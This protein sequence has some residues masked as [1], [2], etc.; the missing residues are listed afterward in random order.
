MSRGERVRRFFGLPAR[1]TA[2]GVASVPGNGDCFYHAVVTALR[3]T[4]DERYRELSVST[5]REL[6]A[7]RLTYD[8]VEV[9]SA[10]ALARVR[11]YDF[12]RHIEAALAAE[13]P[14]AAELAVPLEQRRLA[15]LRS[16]IRQCGT[17]V[18]TGRCIWADE[19][20]IQAVAEHYR[21]T[22][23]ILNEERSITLSVVAP[24]D[25]D[26][27]ANADAA[28]GASPS[29]S[30]MMYV[31]LHLTRR[32]HYDALWF[33]D[34]AGERHFVARSANDLP[35]AIAARFGIAQEAALVTA[36]HAPLAR[37]PTR[38]KRAASSSSSSSSS[39]SLQPL[40]KRQ[41]QESAA[42]VVTPQRQLSILSFVVS[43]DRTVV[44]AID[45]IDAATCTAPST[46]QL[47]LHNGGEQRDAE[48]D[49]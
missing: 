14:P 26:T 5:L 3:S 29:H 24:P 28:G 30:G 41:R 7:A 47:P 6:V 49:R 1:S 19:H 21:V 38:G 42:L 20:A 17:E 33:H 22:F 31:V 45:L 9:Y 18:G 10:L 43:T 32:S 37:P 12:M 39:S 13:T 8:V 44:E 34:R 40:A 27:D 36:A 11:G 35:P 4:N 46:E 48:R 16:A 15:A 2:I 25:A 23:L